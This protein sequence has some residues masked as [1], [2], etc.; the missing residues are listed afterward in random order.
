MV[1]KERKY[2]GKLFKRTNEIFHSKL[3]LIPEA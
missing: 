3:D 2:Y 1:E